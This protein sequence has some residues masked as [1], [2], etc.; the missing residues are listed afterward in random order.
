MAM[1]SFL[2]NRRADL[3]KYETRTP[4]I[5]LIAASLALLLLS[6]REAGHAAIAFRVGAEPDETTAM[7]AAGITS[8]A[9]VLQAGAL[10]A[11]GWARGSAFLRWTGLGLVG[12]TLL[13]VALFDLQR[14]DIFW[15]FVI[16]L[17]VGTVLLVFSFVYQRRSRTAKAD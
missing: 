10:L 7:L 6:A 13:K 9:W 1:A 17:G 12:L 14:V 5:T 2:W 8:A 11:V 15:R 3:G 16:A 4:E